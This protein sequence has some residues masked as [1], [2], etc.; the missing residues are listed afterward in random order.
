MPKKTP[1]VENWWKFQRALF[2]FNFGIILYRRNINFYHRTVAVLSVIM[3]HDHVLYTY[4]FN[5][6]RTRRLQN[7][8]APFLSVCPYSVVQDHNNH[9][10]TCWT[11]NRYRPYILCNSVFTFHLCN[12]EINKRGDNLNYLFCPTCFDPVGPLPRNVT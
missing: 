11:E 6:Q 8:T 12:S 7:S 4:F 5:L 3:V 1:I 10:A 2:I 9:S